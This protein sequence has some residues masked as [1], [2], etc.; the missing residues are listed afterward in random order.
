M[1]DRCLN[2]NYIYY[3]N[4]G[5]RGVT[6]CERWMDFKNF[7]ADM[8]ERP[9]NSPGWK[10]RRAEYSLGRYGD[11]G[12]YEPGNCAWMT[13]A[14]QAMHKRMRWSEPSRERD[15]SGRFTAT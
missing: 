9:P 4:Y 8:G 15:A 10:G 2:P 11:A 5:G 13:Q 6:I 14:E 7:L 3:A 12:N 1:K